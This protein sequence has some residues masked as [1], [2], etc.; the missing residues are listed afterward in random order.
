MG[1]IGR[2]TANSVGSSA[3]VSAASVTVRRMTKLRYV[4]LV[5]ILAG[6]V[7]IAGCSAGVRPYEERMQFLDEMSAKGLEYRSQLQ[8]QGTEPIEEACAKGWT[9]LQANPPDDTGDDVVSGDSEEWLAQVRE[10]YIKAC[11][12]G[13]PRPKPDPD[14]VKAVT[15]VPFTTGAT[16]ATASPSAS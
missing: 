9:L 8:Q 11:M 5:P 14:G 1:G 13:K 4:A 7:S 15:P 2:T 10:S 12:T 3:A 16:T 6:A